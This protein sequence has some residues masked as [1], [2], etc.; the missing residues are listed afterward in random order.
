MCVKQKIMGL[1]N[2]SKDDAASESEIE[3]ALRLANKLM[4]RHHLSEEDLD[5]SEDAA[6]DR[7]LAADK[8]LGHSIVGMKM[9]MWEKFLGAFITDLTGV[10][11]Y[12]T[13]IVRDKKTPSGIIYR[14]EKGKPV[15]GKSVVFYGIAED[16]EI[17][18]KLYDELRL[19]IISLARLRYSSV[20]QGEGGVYA[21]GFVSGLADNLKSDKNEQK[22]IAAESSSSRA[23]VLIERRNDLVRRKCNIAN[24]WLKKEKGVYLR[25]STSRGGSSG[26]S[27]ARSAG[28]SDGK[29]YNVNAARRKKLA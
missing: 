24:N 15:R 10:P 17:A 20:F 25:T 21:E 14:N 1:L 11:R 13:K 9:F 3:T 18:V 4:D 23:M 12:L 22:K 26:S 6:L 29:S 19:V 2:I 28:R 7:A 16:V 5:D 8:D 27:G